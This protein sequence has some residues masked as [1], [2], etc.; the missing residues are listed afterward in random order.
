MP[1]S[2]LD[3][4][5]LVALLWAESDFHAAAEQWFRNNA[6][7]GWAT[8]PITQA[9]FV[10]IVSNPSVFRHAV[11]PDEA[12]DALEQNLRHPAHEFWQ[13]DLTITEA[14]ARFRQHLRGHQQVTDAYLLGLTLHHKGRLVTFDKAV[15][16]L[17]AAAGLGHLVTTLTL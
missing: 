8:C 12:L 14:A 13:D 17:A 4:N 3:V 10:R 15:L 9:G 7:K 2:L 5:V 16:T 11:R 1:A 6:R